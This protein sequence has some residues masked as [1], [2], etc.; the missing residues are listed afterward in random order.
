M[1]YSIQ[2]LWFCNGGSGIYSPDIYFSNSI[3]WISLEMYYS[4]SINHYYQFAHA[5]D[6]LQGSWYEHNFYCRNFVVLLT[7]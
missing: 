3:L 4:V 7:S 1:V 6:G 5:R 2:G